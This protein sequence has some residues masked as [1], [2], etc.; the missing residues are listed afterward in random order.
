MRA[1]SLVVRIAVLAVGLAGCGDDDD[2]GGDDP[3]AVV[4]PAEGVPVRALD[5][6]AGLVAD[7]PAGWRARAIE[8]ATDGTGTDGSAPDGC[9]APSGRLLFGTVAVEVSVPAAACSTGERQEPPLNGRHGRY[10][11]VRDAAAPRSVEVRDGPSGRVTTFAQ[12]YTECTNACTT[13]VDRVALLALTEP[14]EGG[15]RPTVMLVARADE[16]TADQ[17]TRLAGAVHPA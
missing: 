12:D 17:L 14:L 10:V 4:L 6:G 9:T 15:G 8:P 16:L 5:L 3:V 11:D 2:R 13:R 7:L 1:R